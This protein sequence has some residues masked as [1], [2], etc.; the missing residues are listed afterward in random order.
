VA[1]FGFEEI[2]NC[3]LQQPTSWLKVDYPR[4][5]VGFPDVY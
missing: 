2:L 4:V 1:G 5:D 3:I